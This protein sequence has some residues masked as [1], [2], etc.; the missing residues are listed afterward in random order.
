MQKIS[1]FHLATCGFRTAWYE[2]MTFDL[3]DPDTELPT[4]TVINLENGGGKTTLIALL[5]SCFETAQEKFLKHVQSRNNS[6][7]QYFSPD[8]LPGFIVVEW[9]MPAKVAGGKPYRLLTGQV[10]AIRPHHEP[11]DVD[12]MFFAFEEHADLGLKDIPAPGLNLAPV[13][14]MQDFSRW[15]HAQQKKHPG[16][17][18][19]SHNRQAEWQQHLQDERLI[20]LAMLRMQVNFSSQEGGFDTGFLDFKNEPEFLRKFL[21]LTSDASKADEARKL[22]VSVCEKHRRKP[23]FQRRHHELTKF[24]GSLNTFAEAAKQYLESLA[25]QRA[26][27]ILAAQLVGALQARAEA[28]RIESKEAADFEAEQRRQVAAASNDSQLFTKEL[29]TATWAWHQKRVAQAKDA[30]AAASAK[31]AELE[32]DERLIRAARLQK[33]ILGIDEELKELDALA[34]AERDNLKPAKD[35]AEI[36]GA[37]L[38]RTLFNEEQRLGGEQTLLASRA[39]QRELD[40]A[41]QKSRKAQAEA[42]EMRHVQ[43]Q[44]RHRVAEEACTKRRLAL[45]ADGTLLGPEETTEDASTRLAT[46]ARRLG[47]ERDGHRA[48]RDT[49]TNAAKERRTR[50]GSERVLATQA[51]EQAKS[52]GAFIG[53]GESEL[54]RLS[55]LSAL[56]NAVESDRVEPLS[57]A[58]PPRLREVVVES[59]RQ[60]SLS[61]VR[62]AEM[63]AASQA[64]ADT[65]VAG[66]APDVALVVQTLVQAGVRSAKAYNEYIAHVLPDVQRARQLV[67]SDPARFLGVSVAHTELDKARAVAWSGRRPSRPVVVS[68][69]S[70]EST[71]PS[72]DR[73]VVPSEDDSAFNVEAAA[74]LAATLAQRVSDEEQRRLAYQERYEQT[75]KAIQELETFAKEFGD[76]QL[77][78]A[79]TR[80]GALEGDAAIATARAESLEVSAG[81]F[82]GKAA[83]SEVLALA[84]DRSFNTASQLAKAVL[85]FQS[86][87]EAGRAR[88]LELLAEAAIALTEAQARKAQADKA[89]EALQLEHEGDQS[90]RVEIEHQSRVMG[91]ERGRIKYYDKDYPAQEQLQHNPR[92]LETLR[93]IYS[94]A[95]T[96]YDTEEQKR[97][98]FLS[99]KIQGTRDRRT[100]KTTEFTRDFKQVQM[101]DL[102][103]FLE[104]NHA[105][106]LEQVAADL[107]VAKPEQ[108]TAESIWRNASEASSKWFS[109][110]KTNIG[111]AVPAHEELDAEAL[112]V[113]M[114]AADERITQAV[115]RIE[116]ANTAANRAASLAKEKL[117]AAQADDS[118]ALMLCGAMDFDGKPDPVLLAAEIGAQVGMTL[119]VPGADSI[120][121]ETNATD[122][123]SR[124]LGEYSGKNRGVEKLRN[125][126]RAMFDALK[127]AAS[128]PS[129][130]DVDPDVANQMRQNE[131]S[132]ACTDAERLL[133][134]LDDRI[135]TTQATLDS[136]QADFDAC[137]EEVLGVVRSAISTLSRATSHDKSVPLTA[138]YVGGKQVLKMRANFGTI[139][140]EARRQALR[141]YLD[142][143]TDTNTFPQRGTDLIAEALSRTYGRPLGL[144]VLKMS[145]DEAEQYVPVEKVSNSGGEGVVMA[146]FL[147]LVIN[148]LRSENHAQVQR[149]AGGPLILDNPFAKATSPAMWRAQRL[150]A[151]AMNV[152]LIFA[153]AL[154]DLNAIGE[155][156]RF[157]RLRRA[158][159]NNKT[160]RLHLEMASFKLNESAEVAAA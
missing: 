16:D 32:K 7:S 54:E 2:G 124:L 144:Q 119:E 157:I 89:L 34:E 62:L 95:E 18:F 130:L 47:A 143:L 103:P 15:I 132:A 97:L 122:Q 57:P 110:N 100:D 1:R 118:N 149:M 116:R 26:M 72:T 44:S 133:V 153:T 104:V 115:A 120:V 24:R 52:L 60:V 125:K 148:Q 114:A 21:H 131:F 67:A 111:P 63:R 129:F 158:G 82:D 29:A 107:D 23:E 69:A 139:P 46:L 151:D 81:E 85:A 66:Y 13:T 71:A 70:L 112:G 31:V 105:Q 90:R 53:R 50:A 37:L 102:K 136:M 12:R 10:V 22:V 19:I 80:K 25:S 64:I 88:R 92:P 8:G 160:K 11:P 127:T 86:E 40:R 73:V 155:F 79:M 51:S 140:V 74:V 5:F 156:Q 61:N 56:L 101:S 55:Q 123:V 135:T 83:A 48:A 42:D 91:E 30:R 4:D 49:S 45:E 75:L 58:L 109:S 43:E 121:L 14:S 78:E 38:R 59:A 35:H 152:Q 27:L 147:Y 93:R 146:M 141:G 134:H 137:V 108:V 159:Q 87:H 138:P 3:T 94:G 117:T 99:T 113:L 20:D 98:G 106:A 33:D 154:Q 36:Q 126:A 77:G 150:L 6:F 142:S 17:V 76:G 84:A 96:N 41:T 65:G 68:A 39:T 28:K 9:L 128:E 145:V